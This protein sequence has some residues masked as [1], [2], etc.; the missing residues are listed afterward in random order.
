MTTTFACDP[1][2][3][4]RN[5]DGSWTEWDDSVRLPIDRTMNR[6]ETNVTNVTTETNAMPGAVA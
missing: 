3:R 6:R 4:V 1:A 2:I 5:S